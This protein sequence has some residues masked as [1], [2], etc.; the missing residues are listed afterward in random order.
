MLP[1]HGVSPTRVPSAVAPC[2]FSLGL[3]SVVHR[4][5]SVCHSLEGC[6]DALAS[7]QSLQRLQVLEAT[8]LL[9]LRGVVGVRHWAVLIRRARSSGLHDSKLHLAVLNWFPLVSPMGLALEHLLRAC[10]RGKRSAIDCIRRND[11]CLRFQCKPNAQLSVRTSR[12]TPL[13]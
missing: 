3:I 11:V 10:P 12:G 13:S 9:A 8:A 5:E 4:P 7:V 6:A 1:L 2:L